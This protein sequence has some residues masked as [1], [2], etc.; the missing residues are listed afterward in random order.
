MTQPNNFVE[1]NCNSI[2]PIVVWTLEVITSFKLHEQHLKTFG[3]NHWKILAFILSCF[4]FQVNNM[5]SKVHIFTFQINY[6]L[7][8]ELHGLLVILSKKRMT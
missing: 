7:I 3:K 6:F 4:L 8:N 2:K 5:G 1:K